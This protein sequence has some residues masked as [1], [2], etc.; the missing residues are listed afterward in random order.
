MARRATLIKQERAQAEHVLL[1]DAGDSLTGDMDP[2]R[3][4]Q[5]QTSVEAMNLMGY[6]AMALGEEDLAL[7]L[8]VLEQRMAE[9]KF[10]FLSAN[11]VRADTG[12]LLA[13]PYVVREIGGHRVGIIGLT[14]PAQVP[15]I[16]VLDP[17]ETARNAVAEVGKQTDVIILLSHAGVDTDLTIA[18]MVSEIDLIVSGG[19]QALAHPSQGKAGD[20]VV[21]AEVPS[22]GHA[23]RYIG[24]A[25]LQFDGEGRLMDH[26]WETV[27]LTPDFADDPELVAWEE[28]HR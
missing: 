13:Q 28:V 21:H 8:E 11:V 7:G 22:P 18:D 12:K 16:R 10:P 3:R 25:R 27:L 15:G 4:T 9:A 2:A 17:L 6:D 5:G 14:G 23:G 19:S 24:V 26:Q 20:L 1:L